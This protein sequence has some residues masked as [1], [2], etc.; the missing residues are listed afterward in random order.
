MTVNATP[1]GSAESADLSLRLPPPPGGARL[2]AAAAVALGTDLALF[3]LFGAAGAA[4]LTAHVLGLAAAAA[5]L[6]AAAR[7][8]APGAEAP[9]AGLRFLAVALLALFLRGGVL[10]AATQVWGWPAKGAMLLAGAA[11]A[12]VLYLGAAFFAFA[13][14]SWDAAGRWGWAA[15]AVTAYV[16][17]LRLAYLGL[18][19]LLPEEAYY[20]NYSRHLDIGYLDHPPMVAWSIRAGTALFGQNEFGVRFPA[21]LY[22]AVA[23]FF[24]WRL[25]RERYGR[26]AGLAALVLVAALPFFFGVGFFMTPDAPLVAFWSAALYFLARALLDGEAK[27][28]FGAGAAIGLGLLSKYT[29]A[30]LGGATLAF[31]LLD[32]PSRRWLARPAPYLAALLAAAIFSPAIAWNAMNGWASFAFQTANR[33]AARPVFGLHEL[34]G[35][36]LLLLTPAGLAAAAL[37]LGARAGAGASDPSRAEA[38]RRR[39]LFALVFTLAP[40]AVFALFSLRH[41]PKINWTGPL[42]LAALPAVAAGVL[43]LPGEARTARLVRR[44]WTPVLATTLVFYGLALHYLALGLPGVRVDWSRPNLPLGWRELGAAVEEIEEEV[45]RATGREPLVVGMDKYFTASQLSFYDPDGDGPRETASNH[46]FG[47]SGLMFARWRPIPSAYGKDLVL[48]SFDRE[49]LEFPW[50]LACAERWG[51][52]SEGSVGREGERLARFYWRVAYGYKAPDPEAS[53]S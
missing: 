5:L 31:V 28:W 29:I 8:W 45:E 25:A 22:S 52:V 50:V 49:K 32:A 26:A 53:A 44:S 11:S 1:I 12:A 34:V 43:P 42:W 16:A 2:G 35:A 17:L 9:G 4:A 33:L 41:E 27:A 20:W 48:V 36:A 38:D 46:L 14:A 47:G 10:G 39:R 15:A 21:F 3:R 23:A 7:R 51:P 30:L 13:P 24:A 18:P 19:D 6:Y 37:A 40:L